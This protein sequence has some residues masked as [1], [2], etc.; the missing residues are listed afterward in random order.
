MKIEDSG[1]ENWTANADDF[2]PHLIPNMY[3]HSPR[4]NNMSLATPVAREI[5]YQGGIEAGE[6]IQALMEDFWIGCE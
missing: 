4:N 6:G 5:D 1:E 3:I 2:A